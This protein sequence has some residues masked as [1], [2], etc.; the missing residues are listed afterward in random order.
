M[1]WRIAHQYPKVGYIVQP[2][3]VVHY[4]LDNAVL[5]ERRLQ[6]K[7]GQVLRKLLKS[8]LQLADEK[9]SIGSF[10]L[11]ARRELYNGLLATIY[12]GL[13]DD[14]RVM[15]KE[16]KEFFPWYW[17]TA[18]Y[19]LTIFPQVTVMLLQNINYVVYKLGFEKGVSRRWLYTKKQRP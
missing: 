4:D 14:A 17:R 1:W 13:K 8:H 18:A 7:S 12:H 15:V 16:F 6:M 3:V 9:T 5:N 2:I 10:K 11:L 19:V